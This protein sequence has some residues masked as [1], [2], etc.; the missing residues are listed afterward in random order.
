MRAWF[1]TGIAAVVVG[2]LLPDRPFSVHMAQHLLVGDVGPLLLVLGLSGPILRPL[3]AVPVVGRLRVLAHPL[4]ALPLW[5]AAFVVWHL[6]G[7]YDETLRNGPLHALE[8]FSFF[9]AGAL[10]W[11]A[12]VEPLP[13]PTW[14]GTGAKALYVLVVRAIG[15]GIASAFIWGSTGRRTGGLIMFFEGGVITLLVFAWLFL[16]WQDEAERRQQLIDRGTEP[17]LARRTARHWP[18]LQQPPG[19]ARSAPSATARDRSSE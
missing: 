4:A 10:M 8:H 7:P 2:L 17:T 3:L 15:W 18:R 11:S 12:V 1:Y 16:R 5:A 14:F 9:F 19:R 13:G 6:N